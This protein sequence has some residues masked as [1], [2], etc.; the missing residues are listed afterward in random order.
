MNIFQKLMHI[1]FKYDYVY[2]KG[3]SY[4][5]KIVYRVRCYAD[6]TP[7]IV[8]KTSLYQKKHIIISSENLKDFKWL[9]CLHYKYIIED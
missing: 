6:R 7:Y 3:G 9:T 1:I 4:D 8:I 2:Y 5:Y